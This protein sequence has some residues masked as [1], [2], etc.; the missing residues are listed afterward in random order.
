MAKRISSLVESLKTSRVHRKLDTRLRILGLEIMDLL[1]VM[2][3]AAT[4]N[5]FLG[6]TSFAPIFV[7]LL[8]LVLAIIL[9]F[10][11]RNKPENYLLHLLKYLTSSGF[12]SAG[13][14]NEQI[15]LK[16]KI[17]IAKN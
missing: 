16:K 11:K 5:L 9:Y 15:E 4:N 10:I 17:L 14:V 7:L 3:I 13:S 8:P 1:V 12:Y 6:R 2:G